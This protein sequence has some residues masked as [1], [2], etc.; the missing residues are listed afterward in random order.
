MESEENQTS[1]AKINQRPDATGSSSQWLTKYYDD[2]QRI[3]LGKLPEGVADFPDL[4]RKMAGTNPETPH[5]RGVF[6]CQ[7][8]NDGK[9]GSTNIRLVFRRTYRTI[10][11]KPSGRCSLGKLT[12]ILRTRHNRHP[13]SGCQ[14]ALHAQASTV[15]RHRLYW[16]NVLH[17][18]VFYK[19]LFGVNSALLFNGPL[20]TNRLSKHTWVVRITRTKDVSIF[21]TAAKA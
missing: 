3:C 16:P 15:N 9:T 10:T 12:P 14:D 13:Y 8:R 1:A 21:L 7:R 4:R 18:P 17:G 19:V 20:Q 11:D 6:F 5:I 2:A